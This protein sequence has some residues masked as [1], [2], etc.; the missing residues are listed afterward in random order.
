MKNF[1]RY[2]SPFAPDYSG[3]AAV[4]LG[5]GALI[6]ICDP[7]GCSGNVCGYDEPR[8]YNDKSA[9]YSASLRDM[10][11]IWGKDDRLVG[12]IVSAA[13]YGHFDMI[14]LV[15][16]P[17][18]SVIA[19]DLEA[20]CHMVEKQTGI[21]TVSVNTSGLDYY[22]AGEK[23]ARKVLEKRFPGKYGFEYTPLDSMPTEE[24]INEM[25]GMIADSD[26]DKDVNIMIIHQKDAAEMLRNRLRE[27]G[28]TNVVTGGWFSGCDIL[29][30]DEDVFIEECMKYDVICAD[31]LY[32]DALSDYRGIRIPF[33]HLAVSG[34]LFTEYEG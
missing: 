18:V 2:L 23:K 10:D 33:P 3:A 21:P 24:K 20:L 31:P 34:D 8:F 12:K 15:G 7:G 11:A 17:V 19:T 5:C 14:A 25:V 30:K 6:V 22:D 29:F 4:F 1:Y 32:F 26:A 9:I 16:T 27:Q 13:S 28:Y